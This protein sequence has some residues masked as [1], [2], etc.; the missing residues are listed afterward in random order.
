[1]AASRPQIR[2]T[3]TTAMTMASLTRNRTRW[4][5]VHRVVLG[6]ASPQWS[7]AWRAM[8][9]HIQR[10]VNVRNIPQAAR[11]LLSKTLLNFRD[12]CCRGAALHLPR[13]RT[14]RSTRHN[15]V[16]ATIRQR[17]AVAGA[18]LD[19]QRSAAPLGEIGVGSMTWSGRWPPPQ[20]LRTKL[21]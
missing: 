12:R 13:G 4:P 2:P 14:N 8:A 21:P 18:R 20:Q 6:G 11:V 9:C 10:H 3:T 5:P 19:S 1:M 15:S 16:R 7:S 17:G